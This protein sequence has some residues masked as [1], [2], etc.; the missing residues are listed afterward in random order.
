ME[1]TKIRKPFVYER[2]GTKTP[3]RDDAAQGSASENPTPRRR[4]FE[5][6][7]LLKE[8]CIESMTSRY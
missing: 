3:A 2:S 8:E 4:V 7:V 1:R 5:Y 6:T